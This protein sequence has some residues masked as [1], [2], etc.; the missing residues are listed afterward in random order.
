MFLFGT[1]GG[2]LLLFKHL[3]SQLPLEDAVLMKLAGYHQ[4][5][6]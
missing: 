4:L 2:C 6:G 3:H 5:L 1:P